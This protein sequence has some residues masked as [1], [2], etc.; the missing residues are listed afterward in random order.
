MKKQ[1]T[2]PGGEVIEWDDSPIAG[3]DVTPIVDVPGD[4]PDFVL[5][6]SKAVTWGS[7][8]MLEACPKCG[9]FGTEKPC[10][11]CKDREAKA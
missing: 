10:V 8:V 1:I 7:S 11:I 3:A 5:R 6:P 9:Y 2:L 4:V